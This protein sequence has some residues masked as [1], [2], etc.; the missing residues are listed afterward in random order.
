MTLLYLCV[1]ICVCQ[2]QLP[3]WS[4]INASIS[5]SSCFKHIYNH[6]MLLGLLR[7]SVNTENTG[8]HI[9]N[10]L[11]TQYTGKEESKK[12]YKDSRGEYAHE[13]T[14][15]KQTYK[16]LYLGKLQ[17]HFYVTSLFLCWNLCDFS[18]LSD[19]LKKSWQC[20]QVSKVTLWSRCLCICVFVCV[21]SAPMKLKPFMLASMG[22]FCSEP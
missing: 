22:I 14:L 18:Q 2:V 3:Q 9:I 16:R 17:V 1:T 10:I 4:R 13:P 7:C 8:K 20:N 5:I 11:S 12:F 6:C 19:L 21:L 15:K